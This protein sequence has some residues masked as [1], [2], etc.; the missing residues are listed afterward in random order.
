MAQKTIFGI[1]PGLSGA[2]A[3]IRGT[4]L[5]VFDTPIFLIQKGKG[6]TKRE[7]AEVNMA[8][9]LSDYTF[10]QCHAFVEKV[11]SM[12]KQGVSSVFGFG[13]GFGIWRG[14]IAALQIPCTFVTPQAWKKEI[15][16]GIADKDAARLRAQQ[17]FPTYSDLFS[18]KKDEGRAEAALIAYYGLTTI[19]PS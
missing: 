17:L 6:H 5:N 13:V 2:V 3:I 10:E 9:I 8:D 12:P 7:Y 15:M 11:H 14:I 16:Q 4:Q 1:D 19:R 18:R